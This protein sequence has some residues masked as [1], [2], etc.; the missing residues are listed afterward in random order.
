VN[1]IDSVIEN[2][3]DVTEEYISQGKGGY[4]IISGK[5][6]D[7]TLPLDFD[8]DRTEKL[9]VDSMAEAKVAMMFWRPDANSKTLPLVIKWCDENNMKISDFN[10]DLS[11]NILRF[12]ETYKDELW[13]MARLEL[14]GK[15]SNVVSKSSV[16]IKGEEVEKKHPLKSKTIWTGTASVATGAVATIHGNPMYGLL[17]MVY[18][19]LTVIWRFV[20][21]KPIR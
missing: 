16:V 8:G 19:F 9:V 1:K 18:G 21:D 13:Q 15:S 12:R 3:W 2:L 5:G 11:S 4:I 6:L 14:I 10:S 7:E 20:T 17:M